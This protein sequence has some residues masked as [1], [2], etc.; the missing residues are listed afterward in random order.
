MLVFPLASLIILFFNV[1]ALQ[2]EEAFLILR[3]WTVS[4]NPANLFRNI[5][6]LC[7]EFTDGPVTT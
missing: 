6:K 1:Q 5:E 7:E 3:L 2:S 4:L